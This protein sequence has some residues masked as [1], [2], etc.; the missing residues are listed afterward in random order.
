M[1]FTSLIL[2]TLLA[3]GCATRPHPTTQPQSVA[4]DSAILARATSAALVFDPPVTSGQ[5]PI[6]LARAGREPSAFVSY[7]QV[8]TS[9]FYL[10]YQDRQIIAP[11]GSSDRRATTETFG[12]TRR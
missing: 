6:D 3:G 1:R 2:A 8:F 12:V 7:D 5:A 11:D 4:D 9:F 10:R